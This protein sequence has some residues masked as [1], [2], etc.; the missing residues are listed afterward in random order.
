MHMRPCKPHEYEA[1]RSLMNMGTSFKGT[2]FKGTPFQGIACKPVLQW[3]EVWLQW[4]CAFALA[5]SLAKWLLCP[6]PCPVAALVV[7]QAILQL[8]P[9]QH[10]LHLLLV[11]LLLLLLVLL[12][13]LEPWGC[14]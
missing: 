10:H 7:V 1:L 4:Q 8:W 11:F 5:A 14:L 3:V 2:P 6:G 13:V 12:P 9:R